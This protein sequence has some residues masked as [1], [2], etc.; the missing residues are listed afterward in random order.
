MLQVLNHTTLAKKKNRYSRD[1]HEVELQFDHVI[2][3]DI[4]F[5]WKSTQ[6][7]GSERGELALQIEVDIALISHDRSVFLPHE[8][9][10]CND[11]FARSLHKSKREMHTTPYKCT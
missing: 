1:F 3:H 2:P 5:H 4:D 8:Y 6:P 9:L 7:A 10:G 11:F